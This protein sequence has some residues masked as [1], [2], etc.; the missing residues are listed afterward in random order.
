MGTE[1]VMVFWED[2]MLVSWASLGFVK[3]YSDKCALEFKE[4]AP[5]A[6]TLHSVLLNFSPC[7][8]GWPKNNGNIVVGFL[9]VD[10]MTSMKCFVGM[11]LLL[12]TGSLRVPLFIW[13][14]SFP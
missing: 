9:T 14:P 12:L 10:N 3:L 6:H 8:W 11:M 4:K 1:K 2:V 13:S 5:I 7:S